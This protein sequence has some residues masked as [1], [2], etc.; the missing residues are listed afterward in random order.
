MRNPFRSEAEAYRFLLVSIGYFGA[1]A[2]ASWLGGRW[3][4]LAVFIVLTAVALWWLLRREEPEPP[5][6]LTP[7]HRGGE[8]DRRILVIANETV[9]GETLRERIRERSA[10]YNADVLVV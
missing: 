8:N 10:G 3:L 4:G 2:I 9:G 5:P 6:Q 1:I 7:R